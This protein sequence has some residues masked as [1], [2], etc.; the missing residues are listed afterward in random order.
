MQR[1]SVRKSQVETRMREGVL[2]AIENVLMNERRFEGGFWNLFGEMLHE[3]I[4]FK[5]ANP[6]WY[7][8]AMRD[9]CDSKLM[10]YYMEDI[11]TVEKLGSGHCVKHTVMFFNIIDWYAQRQGWVDAWI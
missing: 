9:D 6:K 2:D 11:V 8:H 4:E 7:P 5:E 1:E 3:F 10:R